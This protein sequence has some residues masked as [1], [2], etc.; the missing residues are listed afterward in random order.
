MNFFTIQNMRSRPTATGCTE[1]F[2]SFLGSASLLLE[3]AVFLFK[4]GRRRT[5][6]HVVF[7][8][9]LRFAI[10]HEWRDSILLR[11]QRQFHQLCFLDF[12][13]TQLFWNLL[14]TRFSGSTSKSIL[15]IKNNLKKENSTLKLMWVI[16]T[17]DHVFQRLNHSCMRACMYISHGF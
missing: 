15:T 8:T 11:Q 9:I 14:F 10:H 17:C 2:S 13:R 3:P 12:S 1:C 6:Y 4:E 16:V 5:R 7:L